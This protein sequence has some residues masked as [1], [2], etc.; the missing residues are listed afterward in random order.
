MFF[1]SFLPTNF[2]TNQSP[3]FFTNGW[4]IS[5]FLPTKGRLFA[6]HPMAKPLITAAAELPGQREL[7]E[8]NEYCEMKMFQN[9]I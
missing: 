1:L 5:S 3:I 8:P 6:L 9:E 4:F 2:S 7:E